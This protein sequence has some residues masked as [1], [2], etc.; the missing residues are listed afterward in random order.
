MSTVTKDI[1]I[2]VL[3]VTGLIGFISGEFIISSTIFA[4]AAI[5]SYINADQKK[6]G[7]NQFSWD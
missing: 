3:F 2:A 4:V 5:A 6:R 1:L 7:S